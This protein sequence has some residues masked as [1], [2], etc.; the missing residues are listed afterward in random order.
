MNRPVP[1]RSLPEVPARLR[2]AHAKDN[3]AEVDGRVREVRVGIDLSPLV[4]FFRQTVWPFLD[5]VMS[6]LTEQVNTQ[7]QGVGP[8]IDATGAN[9]TIKPSAA[10]Q[11]VSGTGSIKNLEVPLLQV[12]V[13]ADFTTQRTVSAFTGTVVL[14]PKAASTWTLVT[15]GNIRKAS[16]CVVGQAM[17]LTF[18]GELWAPSY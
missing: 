4:D 8:E 18:D 1:K 13:E 17:Y 12:G 5:R 2:L 6:D 9:I 11:V 7:V 3:A 14:I 10:I 15:G 16:T